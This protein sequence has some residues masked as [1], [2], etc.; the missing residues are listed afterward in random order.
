MATTYPQN[1]GLNIFS[2]REKNS[3][4][5]TSEQKRECNVNLL[6]K[7]FGELPDSPT[8]GYYRALPDKAL[9]AFTNKAL[10]IQGR[11]MADGYLSLGSAYAAAASFMAGAAP[12]GIAFTAAGAALMVDAVRANRSHNRLQ[13]EIFDFKNE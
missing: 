10:H 8:L 5:M 12:V 2:R 7:A 3:A 13:N 11:M 6:R 4:S 9:K 1:S